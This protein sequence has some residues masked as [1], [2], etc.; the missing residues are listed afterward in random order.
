MEHAMD[1]I[2]SRMSKDVL[3]CILRN[4]DIINRIPAAII[5]DP[6]NEIKRMTDLIHGVGC[7]LDHE[8]GE[9]MYYHEAQFESC[10]SQ[11]HHK[12]WLETTVSA[13]LSCDIANE[14]ELLDVLN[15][16]KQLS[17]AKTVS[18]ER[19]EKLR[20]LLIQ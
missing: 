5:R 1:T 14:K 19:A 9:C 8:A 17:F 15:Q 20:T 6:C 10:W 7:E 2:I 12:L 3:A 4:L 18:G 11:P 16:L 13:M